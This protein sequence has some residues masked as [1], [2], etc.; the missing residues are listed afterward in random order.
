VNERPGL[1]VREKSVVLDSWDASVRQV[2]VKSRRRKDIS[3]T[4]SELYYF[5]ALY[6]TVIAPDS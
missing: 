6:V 5:A 4:R 2:N 1:Q 3:M